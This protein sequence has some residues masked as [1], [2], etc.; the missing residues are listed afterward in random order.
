M[1]IYL[2]GPRFSLAERR[3]NEEFA[4]I[5]ERCYMP[6]EVILPQ[7]GHAEN[8]AAP[9]APSACIA[10]PWMPSTTAMQ[11]WQFSTG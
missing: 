2:A 4:R 8:G 5:L 11:S 7:N 6:L 9:I 10:S 1:I 3:L